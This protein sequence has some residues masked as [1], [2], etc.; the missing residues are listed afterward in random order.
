MSTVNV[1]IPCTKGYVV[2]RINNEKV[3]IGLPNKGH[4][5]CYEV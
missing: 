1:I 3:K 2:L 4:L 5:Q